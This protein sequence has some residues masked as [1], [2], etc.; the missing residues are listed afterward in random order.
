MAA[1]LSRS[2]AD[3]PAGDAWL[4]PAERD[5][6]AGLRVDKRRRDW[7]LGRFTA[8]AA[9]AAWLGVT[10]GRVTVVA[11]DDGAPEALV[12]GEPSGA[13]VSLSHRAGRAVAA[14]AGEPVGCDLEVVEP[15]SEAFLGDWLAP[16]EQA[17]VRDADDRALAANLVWT[18]K[19]AAAK[20]WREGLRLD[21]RALTVDLEGSDP[22]SQG[23]SRGLTPFWGEW[24]PL[25]VS[26]TGAATSGWWRRD[27]GFVVT[28][29][30]DDPPVPLG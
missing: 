2:L 10:P 17:L 16:A 21:V 24:R 7:R 14:V 8:K 13:F 11:A 19:E 30:G 5:V 28:V 15:R 9:V 22:L 12:D 6:L 25:R 1:W 3:V 27:A 26:A 4:A 23:D 20:L 29:T 18:A